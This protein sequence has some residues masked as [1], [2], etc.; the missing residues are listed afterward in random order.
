MNQLKQ[1]LGGNSNEKYSSKNYCHIYYACANVAD[2]TFKYNSN[3]YADI[4]RDGLID[5][6]NYVELKKYLI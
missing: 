3:W 4:N 2:V 5:I 6:K 1:I